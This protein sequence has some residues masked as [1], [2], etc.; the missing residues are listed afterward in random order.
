LGGK[1]AHLDPGE[2][3]GD[4]NLHMDRPTLAE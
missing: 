4:G 3:R 2:A 1:A